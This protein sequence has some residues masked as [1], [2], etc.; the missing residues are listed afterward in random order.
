MRALP[1]RPGP[2]GSRVIKKRSSVPRLGDHLVAIVTRDHILAKSAVTYAEPDASV[3]LTSRNLDHHTKATQSS[4]DLTLL[5][6]TSVCSDEEVVLVSKLDKSASSELS[7]RLSQ[8]H[9]P[10]GYETPPTTLNGDDCP[11]LPPSKETIVPSGP[12]ND[13]DFRCG[14]FAASPMGDTENAEPLEPRTARDKR[15]PPIATGSPSK[16]GLY[17]N[18]LPIL[19]NTTNKPLESFE[20][21]FVYTTTEA[22]STGEV[23][24]NA[25]YIRS[26]TGNFS[27]TEAGAKNITPSATGAQ[28]PPAFGLDASDKVK[29]FWDLRRIFDLYLQGVITPAKAKETARRYGYPDAV[30]ILDHA[31]ELGEKD[32]SRHVASVVLKAAKEGNIGDIKTATPAYSS[33]PNPQ[34][35]QYDTMHYKL[36]KKLSAYNAEDNSTG[37]TRI[38]HIFVDISNIHVGFSESWK[39]SQ[40]IPLHHRVR[41]PAFN[42]KV[43]CSIMQRNRPTE[44]KILVGS[45]AHTVT[46][47][48]QWPQHFVEARAQGYKMNILN[49]VQKISS[50]GIKGRRNTPLQ[51]ATIVAGADPTS[52]DESTGDQA[53]AGYATRNG[54][55]GVD[56]L[57][58]LNMMDSVLDLIQKPGTMILATGD[59]ARAEFSDGFLQYATRALD[60]GWNLELVTWKRSISSAWMNPKFRNKYGRRFRIIYLDEFLEELNEDLYPSLA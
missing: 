6:T 27:A 43:L 8:S 11:P 19:P 30:H 49:R 51:R 21:V 47:P 53:K 57:L 9:T 56:E 23:I 41:T 17:I 12:T 2:D 52:S 29:P 1:Q 34:H 40:N 55:Q 26:V 18:G 46:S 7:S 10:Q 60:Q 38:L 39:I 44:K 35:N 20:S 13:K 58:H 14:E 54:E 22:K 48:A 50:G 15:R 16:T 31:T 37:A 32:P 4:G 36:T 59:A 45:V 5:G 24:P 28:R 3:T 25:E 42:F 33:A